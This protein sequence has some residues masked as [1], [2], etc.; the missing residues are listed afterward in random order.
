LA[1][2]A[3][4]ACPARGIDVSTS[5]RY[6]YEDVFEPFFKLDSKSGL[7]KSQREG[8]LESSF[9]AAKPAGAFRVFIVGGSIAGIFHGPGDLE[10]ALKTALPGRSIEVVNCGMNGYDSPREELIVN[11]VL[12]YSPDAIVLMSG[13]NESL[14]LPWVPRWRLRLDKV[15][16]RWVPPARPDELSPAARARATRERLAEFEA[17]VRRIA[18]SSAAKKVPL[19]I[20]APP[21]NLRDGPSAM[22][23]PLDPDFRGGWNRFLLGDCSGARARWSRERGDEATDASLAVFFSARCLEREGKSDEAS[24]A[25]LKAF[26]LDAP[27]LGRCGTACRSVFEKVAREEGA[28]IADGDRAMRALAAPALP[29]LDLFDDRVHWRR[30]A[31][32]AVSAAIVDALRRAPALAGLDWREAPKPARVPPR[33]AS[34]DGWISVLR[35]AVS[36]MNVETDKLGA[37]A[38]IP[39]SV[40]LERWPRGLAAP[41]DELER[42][43]RGS[44]ALGSAWGMEPLRT[45][46]PSF[47][48]HLATVRLAAGDARGAQQDFLT[49]TRDGAASPW[50]WDDRATARA[51]VTSSRR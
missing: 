37:A 33:A 38:W 44:N 1:A 6:F 7:Y 2:L 11:E 30:E 15:R 46:L 47:Y 31:H 40:V 22:H 51:A 19:V 45:P 32:P 48:W 34:E 21:L 41:A 28:V 17:T 36:S 43:E 29:G 3:S 9:A 26:A 14:Q 18:R 49:A 5:R 25:Y 27:L 8:S 4:V 16:P 10:D 24:R 13:H 12:S 39:L 20:L 35:Y 23:L 42:L 50:F